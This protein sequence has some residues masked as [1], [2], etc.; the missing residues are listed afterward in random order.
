MARGPHLFRE[1]LDRTDSDVL[2][3]LALALPAAAMAATEVGD[4]GD[5]PATAQDLSG[6]AGGRDRRGDRRRR[7]PGPL[8]DLH[9]G[10]RQLL[11]H[12]RRRHRARHAALPLRRRRPR[13]LRQRRLS[14]HAP[15]HAARRPRAHAE[16]AGRVPARR[17]PVRPR[18]GEHGRQDLWWGRGACARRSRGSRAAGRLGRPRRPTW[19][20]PNRAHRDRRLRAARRDSALDRADA[21]RR[22]AGAARRRGD[23]GLQLLRRGRLGARVVRGQRA[24]RVGARHHHGRPARC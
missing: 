6:A 15:V 5:L 18:P 22:C 13:R 20:L 3:G 9:R 24:R 1:A 17:D 12:H 2:A 14:G 21:R 8:P 4:A 23:R 7:R 10:R 16:R 11:G 19:R